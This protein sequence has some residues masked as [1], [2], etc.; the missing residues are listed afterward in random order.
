ME[1][2]GVGWSETFCPLHATLNAPPESHKG[3]VSP[4]TLS[5]SAHPVDW[6][7]QILLQTTDSWLHREVMVIMLRNGAAPPAIRQKIF[8]VN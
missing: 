5:P 4:P 6:T 7:V 8:D 2:A 3:Q 1:W